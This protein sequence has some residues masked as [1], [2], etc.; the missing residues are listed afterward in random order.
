MVYENTQAICLNPAQAVPKGND[1]HL[2][3]DFKSCQQQSESVVAPQILLEEW[4]S[5]FPEVAL[6][7]AVDMNQGYWQMSLAR[8]HRNYWRL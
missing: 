6:F 3:V 5:T 2:V 4:T 7:T 8:I 1:Y